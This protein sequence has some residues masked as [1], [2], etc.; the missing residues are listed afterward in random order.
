VVEAE[1]DMMDKFGMTLCAQ[2]IAEGCVRR[3]RINRVAAHLGGTDAGKEPVGGEEE[4][5]ARV[6]HASTRL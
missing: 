4:G 5:I 6:A 1:G 2:G 3:D